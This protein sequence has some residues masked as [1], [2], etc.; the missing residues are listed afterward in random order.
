MEE[1]Q[2]SPNN[3]N[4]LDRAISWISPKLGYA[5]MAWRNAVRGAYNAGEISR[6]SEGWV[7]VNAKAEQVNQAQRDFVR[8]RTRH[9]ERNSDIIGG[10]LGIQERNVVG[11]GFRVQPLTG[12]EELDIKLAD[13]FNDWQLPENCDVTETQSF[14][15][16]CKMA[17]R[18]REVDG[19]ILFVKCWG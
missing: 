17:I 16:I 18:R 3:M 1:N 6:S 9:S 11:T 4:I 5:R 14:F 8:A 13:I 19:G 12:N 2:R 7:P 10:I 15:E